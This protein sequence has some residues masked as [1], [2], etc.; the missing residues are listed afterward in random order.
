MD[1]QTGFSTDGGRQPAGEKGAAVLSL[2]LRYILPLV[3]LAGAVVAMIWMM[4]TG[5]KA[6]PRPKA[7]NATLVE[8]RTVHSGTRQT[9]VHAMGTV[10]PS[11]QVQL[12]PQVSGEVIA[13]GPHLVPGGFFRAGEEVLRIDPT[14]YRIAVQQL[15]SE[16]AQVE[17][18]IQLEQG[19]Q[20]VA[21]KEYELLGE[22]VS[23][24]EKAL[25]LRQ[26]QLDTLKASLEAARG[27][28]EQARV[29]LGRTQIDAP[30]NAVVQSRDINVG[31]RVTPSVP[32]ATLA[33][34]DAFW[35]EISVPVS[36][37]R[38]IRLPGPQGE[39]GSVVR[40]YDEAAWGGEAYRLGHVIRLAAAV[41]PEGRMARMLVEVDDPLAREKGQAGKPILLIGAY[42]RVEIEGRHLD[43]VI[44]LPRD[45]VREGDRAWV[46]SGD[47]RLEIRPLDIL[48]RGRDEVLVNGGVSDGERLVVTDLSA[49]VE[50]MQLRL[51]EDAA[52]ASATPDQGKTQP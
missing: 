23:E 1:Q 43:N 51:Q 26:P 25:M 2:L 48:F 5:P 22:S 34:T 11:R 38:W 45:L 29:D 28:L 36:Q 46:M 50:G 52:Q 8:V 12:M 16:V 6:K 15:A 35:I 24:E 40:V 21:R 33:G 27:R 31:S 20:L 17:A 9:L 44:A 3:I 41:E 39:K 37:L 14:D 49:P 42:V 19:K 4:E 32:L 13:L 47:G 18:E 30:F 7:R 10:M